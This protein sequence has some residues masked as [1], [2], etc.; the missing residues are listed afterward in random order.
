MSPAGHA[1]LVLLIS[2]PNLGLLGS[3][4]PEIYGTS[5]LDD[6]VEV[7][8]AAGS[9]SGMA[10]EHI[11]SDHEGTIVEAVHAARGRAAAIV[12]NA[13]AL[14]HYSWALHDALAAFDGPVVELHLSN[15]GA[16]EGWRHRSVVTPVAT[17]VIA[18]VGGAGYRLAV[19]AVA[20]LLSGRD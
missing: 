14:T 2:G 5:T 16:R 1:P 15:P 18:G 17:A 11:H 19:D 8:R 13:G 3:R 9:A 10:I 7:A 20:A 12:V 6:H 4:Q